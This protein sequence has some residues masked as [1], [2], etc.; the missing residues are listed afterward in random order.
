MTQSFG[1]AWTEQKLKI[2][3]EYLVA[4]TR[5]LSKTPY[6]YGYIDAF[7]GS[8]RVR[9]GAE[10]ELFVDLQDDEPRR[11]LD[12]SARI[13]LSTDPPFKR[14]VFIDNNQ[15][16]CDRLDK[17]V[18]TEFPGKRDEV[19]ILRGDANTELRGLCDKNWRSMRAVLFL[20][21]FGM[22]V[23]WSTIEAVAKT[24]AI[25]MWLLF[26]MTT[27]VCRLLAGNLEKLP[28]GWAAK[29][30]RFFGP[31][32]WSD[33]FYIESPQGRLFSDTPSQIKAAP[34]EHIAKYFK[35]CLSGIFSQVAPSHRMLRN[36][37]GSPLYM[38]CFAAGNP[39]GAPTA[40]KIA[41]Y[42][43]KRL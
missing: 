6:T 32:Q 20:D 43:L 23:D 17:L 39:R 31:N 40:V 19:R 34:P 3:R 26:P 10:E 24:R 18:Q 33:A 35:Q 1:G 28:V 38:L 16:N 37:Q 5:I 30:D 25:D 2:L 13:A 41:D 36:S 11:L 42:L 21:P 22:Q 12:G 27:G 29:L 9:I 15:A 14:F 8:G 4:Y 7:A